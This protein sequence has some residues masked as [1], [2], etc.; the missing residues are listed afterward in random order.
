MLPETRGGGSGL[1]SRSSVPHCG[2]GI[3]DLGAPPQSRGPHPGSPAQ[4]VSLLCSFLPRIQRG[5]GFGRLS[6]VKWC[7]PYCP[8]VMSGR[9]SERIEIHFPSSE[10][11]LCTLNIL[12]ENTVSFMQIH[13]FHGWLLGFVDLGINNQYSTAERILDL[14]SRGLRILPL[15]WLLIDFQ[16][17][18]VFSPL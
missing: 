2:C 16:K 8:Q 17:W 12:S 7:S 11:L 9:E 18:G 14:E 4:E 13:V 3:R 1:P 10:H 15:F 5:N 6:E